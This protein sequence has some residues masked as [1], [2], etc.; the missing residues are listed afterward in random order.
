MQTSTWFV[1]DGLSVAPAEGGEESNLDTNHTYAAWLWGTQDNPQSPSDIEHE[2]GHV[3]QLVHPFAAPTSLSATGVHLPTAG[4]NDNRL[5]SVMSY[6]NS[7]CY[8]VATHYGPLDLAAQRLLYG[9]AADAAGGETYSLDAFSGVGGV[10]TTGSNN[11]FVA[12]TPLQVFMNLGSSGNDV[13]VILDPH[14]S[15][16]NQS[17]LSIDPTCVMNHGDIANTGGGSLLGNAYDNRLV[18][19]DAADLIG[20]RGGQDRIFTGAGRDTVWLEAVPGQVVV[21]DFDPEND[22][23]ATAFDAAPPSVS[24]V[25]YEGQVA[26]ELAFAEGPTVVLLG[27]PLEALDLQRHL[28]RNVNPDMP[29]QGGNCTL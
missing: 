18:G 15:V 10:Q 9:T 19:S 2:I 4:W 28:L 8:P 13:S 27:V 22:V 23:L 24:A 20:G 14:R 11:T 12:S 29:H 5:S 21:E 16:F 25:I 3:L 6:S 17:A 26:A 1:G 7:L